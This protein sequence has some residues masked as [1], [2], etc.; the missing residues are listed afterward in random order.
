MNILYSDKASATLFSK[1]EGRYSIVLYKSFRI[2]R[3]KWKWRPR[4]PNGLHCERWI[5]ISR[6]RHE[7]LNKIKGKRLSQLVLVLVFWLLRSHLSF[8]ITYLSWLKAFLKSYH[9][10]VFT[11]FLLYGA[12]TNNNQFNYS[13]LA[14]LNDYHVSAFRID[15]TY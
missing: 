11:Y 3:L 5:M 13:I 10:S 9:Y 12:N 15:G 6:V 2:F 7:E 4:C 14:V 8:G 1:Y